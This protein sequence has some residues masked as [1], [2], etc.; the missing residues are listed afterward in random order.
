MQ[1]PK[2][3]ICVLCGE[4]DAS[5]SEHVP[6][7]GF[8]KGVSGQ[9][10]TV[11][12]CKE[13]NNG[14]S[15]DDELLRNYLSAEIGGETEESRKLWEDGAHRSFLRSKKY[16][17]AL[18]TSLQEVIVKDK[19]GNEIKK[20][21]FH[22]P[23]SL[24]HRIFSKITKGLFFHHTASILALDIPISIDSL[25]SNPTS[26]MPIFKQLNRNEICDGIFK[27]WYWAEGNSSLW[28]YCFHDTHWIMVKT[29]DVIE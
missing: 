16:R 8:F 27:Y 3:S 18:F 9:F 15:E 14:S 12:A 23:V 5:T 17:D 11:P 25:T 20:L 29:G 7:R 1:P 22:I 26:Y 28:F 19:N 4:N 6:P 10:I 2:S 21:A 13:C 24:Y